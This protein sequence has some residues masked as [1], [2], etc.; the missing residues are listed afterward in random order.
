MKKQVTVLGWTG[1]GNIGDESYKLAFPL[2]FKDLDFTFTNVISNDCEC[3]FLGGG[4]IMH[5]F[6]FKSIRKKGYT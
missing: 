3:V 5:P 6:F 1:H 2:I 4:N